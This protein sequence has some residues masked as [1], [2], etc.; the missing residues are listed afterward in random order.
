[1]LLIE[2]VVRK[3]EH[4]RRARE[5]A[6]Q[7]SVHVRLVS[8][9]FRFDVVGDRCEVISENE[10]LTDGQLSLLL[11]FGDDLSDSFQVI[12]RLGLCLLK[13]LLKALQVKINWVDGL[14]ALL[15]DPGGNFVVVFRDL[16][17]SVINSAE[18]LNFLAV[19]VV[20][21]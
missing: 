1:M 19:H 13:I 20:Q 6:Y 3:V 2:H 14:H 5:R 16:Q 9:F 12:C 7:Q 17:Y 4:I 8:S 18:F 11:V 21:H 10:Y 15:R